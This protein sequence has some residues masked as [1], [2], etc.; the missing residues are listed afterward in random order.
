MVFNRPRIAERLRDLRGRR[1]TIKEVSNACGISPST[2]SMYENG[3]RVPRDEVK[4]RLAKFYSVSVESIFLTRYVAKRDKAKKEE[5][6]E[7]Q[8]EPPTLSCPH[9]R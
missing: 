6:Y 1:R 5:P 3:E 9:R 4:I 2:L 7:Q 8:P